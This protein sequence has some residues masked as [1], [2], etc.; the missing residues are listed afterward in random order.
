MTGEYDKR[1][2]VLLHHTHTPISNMTGDGGNHHV[3]Y[4]ELM[5][6]LPEGV[7]AVVTRTEHDHLDPGLYEELKEEIEREGGTYREHDRHVYLEKDDSRAAII[8]G[9]EATVEE[10]GIH[11]T[12][13]GLPLDYDEEFDT[14]DE[15]ELYE[16]AKDAAWT[17]PAHP[18]APTF[19]VP[20]EMLERFFEASE[21]YDFQA[22]IG[23]A[24]GYPPFINI[25]TQGRVRTLYGK[26]SVRDYAERYDVPLVPELD[27]HTVLP[28]GL[29]GVGVV[30][31]DD[32]MERL[33]EGE[34]PTE[35]MLDTEVVTHSDVNREGL[36]FVEF[37]QSFPRVLPFK[38]SGIYNG[39]IPHTDDDFREKFEESLEHLG[40]VSPERL[41]ESTYRPEDSFLR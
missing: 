11:F 26:Q 14:I 27:W 37:F 10:G 19:N 34:I 16:R 17:A 9:V 38:G 31:P 7:D 20:D 3:N 21:E 23:Y 12:L 24:T 8:N 36:S 40:D 39:A 32:V 25:V 41:D 2:T 5:E 13:C 15:D 35:D 4:L 1:A 28:E 6:Y 18:F 22:G 33:A 29:E 30:R